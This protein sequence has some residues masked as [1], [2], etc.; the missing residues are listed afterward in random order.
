MSLQRDSMI[1]AKIV[2]SQ[3]EIQSILRRLNRKQTKETDRLF[4]TGHRKRA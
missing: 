4:V 3:K 2:S 1:L